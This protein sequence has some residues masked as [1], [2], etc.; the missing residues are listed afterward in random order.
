MGMGG[1]DDDFFNRH[2]G[3]FLF[4]QLFGGDEHFGVDRNH[5]AG[6]KNDGIL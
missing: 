1:V 3:E 5:I 4:Q 6:N 2:G